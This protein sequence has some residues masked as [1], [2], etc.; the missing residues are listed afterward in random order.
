MK[1]GFFCAKVMSPNNNWAAKGPTF[2]AR[3]SKVSVARRQLDQ[4]K[5]KA[6][7]A[8]T[9]ATKQ[10]SLRQARRTGIK[11][12]SRRICDHILLNVLHGNAIKNEIEE[13]ERENSRNRDYNT[14]VTLAM[15]IREVL[16]G[17]SLTESIVDAVYSGKDICRESG[18]YSEA[19]ERLPT[20]LVLKLT[21]II[22]MALTLHTPENL[23][24]RGRRLML[25][26]GTEVE[27]ED[28]PENQKKYPQPS[29]QKK[30]C[31]YPHAR[32]VAVIAFAT[33]AVLGVAMGP[34]EG[35]STGEHALLRR[36][37]SVFSEGDVMIADS[38]YASY[39]LVA[40]LM[41]RGVDFVFEQH[42]ARNTDFRTG[43]QLGP[44]DHK[45]KWKKPV[46]PKWMSDWEYQQ[47]PD[48]ITVREVKV[49]KKILVTSFLSP[50]EVSRKEVGNLFAK[51]WNIELGFRNI[52]TTLGMERLVCRTP[53]MCEKELHVYMLAYNLIR[54]LMVQAAIQAG[55]SPRQLSFKHAVAE[56][57]AWSQQKDKE[58]TEEAI[59]D[60]LWG[61]GSRKVGKRPGRTEPRARKG[62]PKAFPLL[63]VPRAVARQKISKSVRSENRAAA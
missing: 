46:K 42:G 18:S 12:E 40:A 2:M 41:K 60:L 51:R 57:L 20:K 19:R 33:A 1:A 56:W 36:T 63:T 31:G 61:V 43:K 6:K 14:K 44:Q 21:Y 23:Q 3:K 15:F 45:V 17:N 8:K 38:Y 13:H 9:R 34:I 11:A 25:V 26:D 37:L 59:A 39:F 27:L 52:K 54:L 55:V 32:L 16:K 53:D 4:K 7:S 35:E 22:S 48:E 28:T 49:G 58:V 50:R 62:R 30:G 29:T 24:W 10:R 47:Y 5:R